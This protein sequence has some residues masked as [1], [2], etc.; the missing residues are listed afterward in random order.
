MRRNQLVWGVVLLLVGGFMFANEMGIKLPNGDRK[1]KMEAQNFPI[2]VLFLRDDDIPQY[3]IG[4][5][6]V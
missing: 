2:E 6:H 5:A 4:R 1:L 3:E